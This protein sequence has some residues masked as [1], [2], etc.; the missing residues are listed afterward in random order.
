MSYTFTRRNASPLILTSI[1]SSSNGTI[2]IGCWN[3]NE[4]YFS[5]NSG[6]GWTAIG[7]GNTNNFGCTITSS[8]TKMALCE[9]TGDIFVSTTTGSTWNKYTVPGASTQWSAVL[10]VPDGSRLFAANNQHI[11]ES[12]DD[13]VN[14]TNITVSLSAT[15]RTSLAVTDN[16]ATLLA[17]RSSSAVLDIGTYSS[18]WSWST[19][20]LGSNLG[21]VA[22]SGDGT[23]RAC[24]LTAGGIRY[25]ADSGVS[26]ANATGSIASVICSRVLISN[27]GSRY[28]ALGRTNGLVYSTTDPT[29]TWTSTNI[30]SSATQYNDVTGNSTLSSI[31]VA[32]QEDRMWTGQ[33]Q[34]P[35]PVICFRDGSKILTL[36]PATGREEYTAVESLCPGTLVKTHISGYVPICMIGTS[37]VTIPEGTERT[38]DRLYVCTKEQFPNLTEDLYITGHHSILVDSLTDGEREACA[39]EM[40]RVYLTECRYR[41]PAHISR[42]TRVYEAP[43]AVERIWHFALENNDEQMNYGVYANGLL[44]ES[45][46]IWRLR[47]MVGY[48]I[49]DSRSQVYMV[50]EEGDGA[51]VGM[52]QDTVRPIV[53]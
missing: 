6:V 47:T 4:P 45:C 15:A 48:T 18:S 29:G 31:Y 30:G 9:N 34:S 16:G 1:A 32:S 23:K 26:W 3:G 38:S 19:T 27:N 42:R 22:M 20:N 13:G 46:S 14:W 51:S 37:T 41:L 17:T 10:Y 5:I 2:L 11:Y 39:E 44:V 36:N 8:G 12:T 21:K 35:P 33:L 25:S 24:T 53:C 52:L 40:G 28:T 43:G 50:G 7:G 49:M